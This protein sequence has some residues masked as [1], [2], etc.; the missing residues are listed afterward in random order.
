MSSGGEPSYV[1]D[2]AE[3]YGLSGRRYTY[4]VFPFDYQFSHAQPANFVI[5]RA[6]A[7]SDRRSS[8]V[9]W[10]PLCIGDVLSLP[11]LMSNHREMAR[12]LSA[13]ATHV[14]V[15]LAPHDEARRRNEVRDLQAAFP[16]TVM[17]DADKKTPEPGN[18]DIDVIEI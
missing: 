7:S 15:H 14:H 11:A 9:C 3:W 13:G 17:P 1:I 8:E 6:D 18:Y 16:Q 5:A 4:Y 2:V 12:F 10:T